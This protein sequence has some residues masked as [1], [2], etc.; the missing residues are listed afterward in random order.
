[1]GHARVSTVEQSPALQVDASRA[2]GC[3]RV[4][5]ERALGKAPARPELD[6][7][8]AAL[9]A[10]DTLVV[11]KPD[12]LGRSVAEGARRLGVSRGAVY[13]GLD[14]GPESRGWFDRGLESGSRSGQR[15]RRPHFQHL[16]C[17][18]AD[19]FARASPTCLDCAD[20]RLFDAAQLGQPPLRGPQNQPPGANEL[21][22]RTHPAPITPSVVASRSAAA[23]NALSR[24]D[25]ITH[26]LASVSPAPRRVGLK[27]GVVRRV[28]EGPSQGDAERGRAVVST[29]A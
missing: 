25:G 20:Q 15:L 13:A 7:L 14:R 11:W 2:A 19:S 1:M 8:L 27:V 28:A 29:G 18:G 24:P 22:R 6:A 23:L 17:G 4:W 10:A 3:G 21:A 26:W 9:D 16:N 5:T 12:R